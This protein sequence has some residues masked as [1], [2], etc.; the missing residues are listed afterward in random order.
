[1]FED[2]DY[3]D[4]D[5]FDEFDLVAEEDAFEVDE[6]TFEEMEAYMEGA[7]LAES[8]EEE[9]A[10]L[11]A[12]V[13]AA[14]KALPS[15]ISVGRKLLPKFV[16]AAKQVVRSVRRDPNVRRA[17]K[18]GVNVLTRT[19]Q[20][21]ARQYARGGSVSG[22]F[23]SRRAAAHAGRALPYAVYRT[24]RMPSPGGRRYHRYYPRP[25]RYPSSRQRRV[26]YR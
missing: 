4:F 17:A 22:Q 7:L 5:D 2:D 26:Y 23:I 9:D 11:G 20:D 3:D 19:A 21:V 24:R 16:G 10:F 1:M 8:E 14:T 18:A 25:R 13:S 15:V 12:L 6:D